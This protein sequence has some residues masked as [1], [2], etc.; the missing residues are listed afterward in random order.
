[1]LNVHAS[2]LPRHRG[3]A[4]IQH[5][6]LA[7]DEETGI[8]IFYM[9]EG[10]DTGDI[11]YQ[12]RLA[13]EP[14]DTSG[15]L[16]ERLSR[17]AAEALPEAL[18]LLVSEDPPRRPQ[19]HSRAT[20]APRL[21]PEDERVDW[22]LPAPRVA[23]RIRALDPWPGAVTTWRGQ[24][25]KLFAAAVA[26][27]NPPPGTPPGTVLATEAARGL[28]VAAGE[29]AVVVSEAQVPGGR[30]MAVADFLNGHDLRAGE[31]LGA[32]AVHGPRDGGGEDAPYP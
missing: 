18:A 31:V 6:L 8:T 3:A 1:A 25:P 13:I 2:L 5:A 28:A 21:T 17:L 32:E 11:L 15:T 7:G 20:Y 10:M 30:R 26:G 16:H 19:D 27:A 4:P 23:G 22:N 24:P 29:G 14:G 9:D 12:R